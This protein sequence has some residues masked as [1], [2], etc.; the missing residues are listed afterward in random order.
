MGSTLYGREVLDKLVVYEQGYF[1][2]TRYWLRGHEPLF[3]RYGTYIQGITGPETV[4]E[5][6]DIFPEMDG[7]PRRSAK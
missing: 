5:I 6:S 2:R 4:I 3:E 1:R 7:S